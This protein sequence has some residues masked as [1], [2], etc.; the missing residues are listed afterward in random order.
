MAIRISGNTVI[1]DSK[2]F[3]VGTGNTASRPG[4]P[5][6][7]MLWFNTE[8]GTFEG[9]NSVEWGAIGGGADELARTLATLAL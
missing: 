9:Y 6:T 2:I 5:L 7:G 4:T 8:L 1:D 3:I